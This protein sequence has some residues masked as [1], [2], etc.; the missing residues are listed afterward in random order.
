MRIFLTERVVRGKNRFCV[1]QRGPGIR[2]RTIYKTK[3]KAQ[4]ALD[5][6]TEQQ[7]LAGSDWATLAP[8][9]RADALIVLREIRQAGKSLRQVWGEYQASK[10]T[11][12][13]RTLGDAV[14]DTIAEA[15]SKGLRENSVASLSGYL[16][17]FKRGR[18]SVF[19]DEFTPE[20]I[21]AW[22][23][24]R[25]EKPTTRQS[26]LGRLSTLFDLC[27][28][29]N[30]ITEN[31][32]GKATRVR[33][34]RDA[35]AILTIEQVR[36]VMAFAVK[37]R[38][39]ALAWLSLALFAGTR[40]EE[41]D[42][43]QWSDVDLKA[44][45]VKIDAAASKVGQRRIVHLQPAAVAW[46][47]LAKKKRARLGMPRVTRRRYLRSVRDVLGFAEWPADVLRHSCASYWLASI[48]DAGKVAHELGNSASVLLRH[49][50][51]LVTKE[52]AAAFWSFI[53][54]TA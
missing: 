30:W 12:A 44:G 52:Q 28:R 32:C 9:E 2:K 17:Q 18:E 19:V 42:R 49:Y 41:T 8:A 51:E 15:K 4:A 54:S 25:K 45:I 50:K 5:A 3:A 13:R 39:E 23:D 16:S 6:I 21:N 34:E 37:E 20:D 22:F 53:P 1:E 24:T 36:K 48:Q 14:A 26:N 46:L 38:P 47:T 7:A 10:L 27:W 31:P 11:R 35:P 43:L 40:P 29:R 33:I